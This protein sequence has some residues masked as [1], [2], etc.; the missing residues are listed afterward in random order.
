MLEWEGKQ[1]I[2]L[3]LMTQRSWKRTN[4]Y[5]LLTRDKQNMIGWTKEQTKHDDV[6]RRLL[7]VILLEM[8]R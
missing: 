3:V 5:G 7:D 1:K 2:P 8:F 4:K 6:L